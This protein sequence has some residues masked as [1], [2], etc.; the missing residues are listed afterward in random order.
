MCMSN[1]LE[2]LEPQEQLFEVVVPALLGAVRTLRQRMHVAAGPTHGQGRVWAG[3]VFRGR[4]SLLRPTL[5]AL[6]R[7]Q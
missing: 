4:L 1:P 5:P 7:S 6:P 3:F 2:D